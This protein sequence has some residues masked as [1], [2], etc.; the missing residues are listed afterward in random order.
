MMNFSH[1][2]FHV[3]VVELLETPVD[4]FSP[5]KVNIELHKLVNFLTYNKLH[6]VLKDS[7]TSTILTDDIAWFHHK[8]TK[9]SRIRHH[10]H[11][12][13]TV[14]KTTFMLLYGVGKKRPGSQKFLVTH[15]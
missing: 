12:M 5:W 2:M 14:Y 9:R 10:M 4:L 6:L 1:L 15:P 3:R 8:P 11:N 7:F 13:H